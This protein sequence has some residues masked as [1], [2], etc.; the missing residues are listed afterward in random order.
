M[1]ATI[2][3][4]TLIS[5]GHWPF[6][7]MRLN[8]GKAVFTAW[9]EGR[10]YRSLLPGYKWLFPPTQKK[11]TM[12]KKYSVAWQASGWLICEYSGAR[13]DPAFYRAR[14]FSRL[15]WFWTCASFILWKR[16]CWPVINAESNMLFFFFSEIHNP[17]IIWFLSLNGGD[18]VLK[19]PEAAVFQGAELRSSTEKEEDIQ[20]KKAEGHKWKT[21]A[22][23]WEVGTGKQ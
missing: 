2:N 11:D 3:T 18:R 16:R 21:A 14:C 10:T 7:I 5:P 9:H 8:R 22:I 20:G 23:G 6:S 13:R 4:N 17:L 19:G 12:I 1:P 15:P